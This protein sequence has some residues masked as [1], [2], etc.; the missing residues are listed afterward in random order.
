MRKINFNNYTA[1]ELREFK[2]QISDKLKELNWARSDERIGRLK[3]MVYDIRENL[4]IKEIAKKYNRSITTITKDIYRLSVFSK[5]SKYDYNYCRT[6]SENIDI[7]KKDIPYLE[8][9]L[10]IMA[11]NKQYE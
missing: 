7:I 4:S 3:D 5:K 9:K 11:E 2:K 6:T 10:K 8:Q 1:I